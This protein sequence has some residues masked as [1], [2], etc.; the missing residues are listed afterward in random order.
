MFCELEQ[1]ELKVNTCP[2]RCAY[3]LSN[4]Q[5]GYQEL[6]A[7]DVTVQKIAELRGHKVYRVK[8]Q[9]ASS[10]TMIQLGIMMDR[11]A[12]YIRDPSNAERANNPGVV[13]S[14]NVLVTS[15]SKNLTKKMRDENTVPAEF[16]RRI[17]ETESLGMI[18][19]EDNR[20]SVVNTNVGN[21]STKLSRLF[22]LTEDQQRAFWS[23]EK[24]ARWSKRTKVE[25]S[26]H[27][28]RQ[29]LVSV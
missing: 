15:G 21:V 11:Y 10:K 26:L 18:D 13:S 17:P 22:N 1:I 24:F 5:C 27:D 7:E 23:E 12:D 19:R 9:A 29:A 4:G 28:V 3:R 25:F 8:A 2:V 16:F 20:Q 14:K 6:T